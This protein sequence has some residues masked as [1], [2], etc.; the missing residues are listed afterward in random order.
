M[1][2]PEHIGE[3]EIKKLIQERARVAEIFVAAVASGMRTLIMDGRSKVLNGITTA[4]ECRANFELT[5]WAVAGVPSPAEGGSVVASSNSSWP[6]S[7]TTTAKPWR[8][9]TASASA[10]FAYDGKILRLERNGSAPEERGAGVPAVSAGHVAPRA[11]AW[12]PDGA[13]ADPL[14]TANGADSVSLIDAGDDPVLEPAP[15]ATPLWSRTVAIGLFDAVF[16]GLKAEGLLAHVREIAARND[17][18]AI[19]LAPVPQV[20]PCEATEHRRPPRPRRAH[21]LVFR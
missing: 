14:L 7:C 4:L 15:G 5:R 19:L 13:Y 1:I 6:R 12:A 11:M 2:P 21:F 3:D 9:A 16:P 10:P 20:A 8:A 17:V 18:R